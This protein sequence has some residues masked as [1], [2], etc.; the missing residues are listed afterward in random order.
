MDDE[1]AVQKRVVFDFEIEFS[2][3]GGLKGRDF[4]LD[5][6]PDERGGDDIDDAALAAYIVRDLRLLM[7][8]QVRIDNKRIIVEAHKRPRIEPIAFDDEV[9][10]LLV[11]AD[12]PVA[13]L[14]GTASPAH[15]FGLRRNGVLVGVVG[16]EHYGR[17][18]LLRSLAVAGARR[19][20]GSGGE[21]L[22]H[23]EN[24][25]ARSG[26][27][28]LYLLTT[29]AAGFF[30]RH[31][32]RDCMRDAAPEAIAATAQFAGLCPAS[33]AFMHRTLVTSDPG[34]ADQIRGQAPAEVR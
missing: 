11:A 21:L 3:G 34:A 26:V 7:V 28:Q 15:L 19:H 30:A 9:A 17:V 8:G 4:R 18:A 5:L 10:A 22:R 14:G 24:W 6:H 25:A 12:L 16:L 33:S 13:D 27:Q 20:G 32:Y 31:G 1:A 23:A 2:N 29:T